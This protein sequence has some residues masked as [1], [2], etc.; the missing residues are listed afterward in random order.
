MKR[1]RE[2]ARAVG[3]A[4]AIVAAL[5][6]A[7][8]HSRFPLGHRATA[9]K[10][11]VTLWSAQLV[12]GT[13]TVAVMSD[14]ERS[15]ADYYVFQV[16]YTGPATVQL[17]VSMNAGVTW[18]GA[19]SPASPATWSASGNASGIL[20]TAPVIGAG[21]Y[22]LN[23][24]S[25]G[26]ATNGSTPTPTPSGCSVTAIA[27]VAGS[28]TITTPTA[29]AT[30]TPTSTPANTP[31]RTFTPTNT[32]TVTPTTTPTRTPTLTPTVT[33]TATATSTPTATPTATPTTRLLT[34]NMNLAN[35]GA[36]DEAVTVTDTTASAVLGTCAH[37]ITCTY[38]IPSGHA[39]SIAQTTGS[40]VG[41]WSG[42]TCSG[43]TSTPCTIANMNGAKTVT[44]TY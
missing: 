43:A 25:C 17:E 31:T 34:V 22:R 10:I 16:V 39:V 33:P 21:M 14:F 9:D 1:L 15:G 26:A 20:V 42:G 23:Y 36:H 28:S 30:T 12:P 13:K 4:I 32:P 8:R 2:T 40:D 7:S 38:N 29:T 3:I 35:S 44:T 37:G 41:T 18:Y 24:V 27:S 19:P 5:T 11:G 6:V